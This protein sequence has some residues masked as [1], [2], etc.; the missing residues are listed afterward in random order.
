MRLIFFTDTHIKGTTP[1]NRTDNFYEALRKKFIEIKDICEELDIDY[2]LHG[3]DWFDRPDIAP[4]IVKEFASI[5]QGYKRPV[6]TI[7]GNHD[8][9]GHNPETVGRTMLGLLEG[10]GILKL[11]NYKDEIVLQKKD[12]KVQLTGKPYRF[13]IDDR[14]MFKEY[15]VVKKRTDVTYLINMVHG[16]L[17]KKPFF[18][19]IPYTLIDSILE[20]EAD[21]TLAGHYHGGFGI[22]ERSGKYFVN[23]GSLVRITNAIG[24]I[25]RTPKVVIIDIENNIKIYERE[26]KCA[27]P[28]EEILDRKQLEYA[29]DRNVK[30]YKFYQELSE[31]GR[32]EK[33]DLNKIIDEISADQN[34]S[35]EV[36]DETIRR[37][38]LAREELANGE[39]E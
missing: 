19:G 2:V 27:S 1:K 30:L 13:D 18:E 35:R 25:N 39:E 10:V 14:E 5:I 17:L 3:G 12:V 29:Q 15:Y 26:L 16:M 20:T 38:A 36:K 22:V 33:T 24:E 8:I 6:F 31:T 7:A 28:G 21:I 23:P 34:I 32:F 4:S 9:Y 37:I 11:L